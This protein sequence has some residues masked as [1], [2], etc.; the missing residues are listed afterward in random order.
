MDYIVAFSEIP[1]YN[2]IDQQKVN[3]LMSNID[4]LYVNQKP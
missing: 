3:G 1:G 4:Y 2:V